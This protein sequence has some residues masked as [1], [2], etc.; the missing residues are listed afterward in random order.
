MSLQKKLLQITLVLFVFFVVV[1]ALL[2]YIHIGSQRAKNLEPI[3]PMAPTSTSPVAEEGWS[4]EE[5][6]ELLNNL[7]AEPTEEQLTPAER[8]AALQAVNAVSMEEGLSYED[9]QPR[10]GDLDGQP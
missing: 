4:A 7:S 8:E 6:L 1:F 3:A 9:R 10:L 5:R 2:F